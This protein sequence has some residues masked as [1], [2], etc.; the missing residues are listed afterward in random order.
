M[1]EIGIEFSEQM[2]FFSTGSNNE[3]FRQFAPNGRVPCLINNNNESTQTVWDSLAIIEY[4]AEHHANVWPLA[5]DARTWARCA[6]AEMH[7][8]FGNVRTNCPMNVSAR[9]AM[10]DISGSFEAEI[11][12]I[13]ELWVDGLSRFEGPFLAGSTFS[14]VDAFFAPVVFRVQSY[15]LPVSERSAQYI[16]AMLELNGMQ[17]WVAAALKE[18]AEPNHEADCVLQASLL[19]DLRM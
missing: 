7:S 17:S 19:T 16:Q 9:F 2:H 3:A 15:G 1:T 12:R 11:K 6:A 13:D 8:G 10:N 14:A 4:L 5:R 18:P